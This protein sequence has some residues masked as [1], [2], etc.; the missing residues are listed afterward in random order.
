AAFNMHK[1]ANPSQRDKSH[2]ANRNGAEASH[3][4]HNGHNGHAEHNGQNGHGNV[5]LA[6]AMAEAVAPA[7][8]ANGK[9]VPH[10]AASE[11]WKNGID[12]PV[13]VWIVMVHAL[14]LAAPFFFSWQGVVA[15][16]LLIFLT[17]AGG[18]CMG[19][20]R[21]LTHGSFQT[22]RPIRWL[23]AFLGGLS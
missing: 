14:A 23:L 17:G 6:E 5:A 4:S 2:E 8:A 22:Y 21:C 15:A 11:R 9:V 3:I 18:V 13:V 7:T 16:A 20:H 12:W 1:T 19:Y 10:L